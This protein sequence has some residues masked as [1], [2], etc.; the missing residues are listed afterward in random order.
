VIETPVGPFALI[1]SALDELS[2]TWVGLEEAKDALPPGAQADPELLPGLSAR[3]ER[4]F[5]GEEVSFDDVETPAGTPFRQ[6]CWEACRS[7]RRGRT[8]T[9]AELA[10]LAG[11]VPGAARAAGQAM[12]RNP[13]P[14]IIPCHRVIAS[15]GDL[16]GYGGSRD[17]GGAQIAVK[18]ALLALEGACPASE[19]R[20]SPHGRGIVW[21]EQQKAR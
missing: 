20:P 6:R 16:Y 12:R 18:R 5:A 10:V 8:R 15:G 13:L 4:Y 11:S 19:D 21:F 1:Q 3:L 17:P 9:Y 14:V 2:A 7:I